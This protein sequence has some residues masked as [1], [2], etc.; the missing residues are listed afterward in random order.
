MGLKQCGNFGNS[1]L[2]TRTFGGEGR[3]EGAEKRGEVLAYQE[4]KTKQAL[5]T[6]VK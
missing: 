4:S 3:E 1:S 6:N 2:E 5:P